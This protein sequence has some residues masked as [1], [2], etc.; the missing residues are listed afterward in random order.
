MTS[1]HK[2]LFYNIIEPMINKTVTGELIH[3]KR[4]FAFIRDLQ[5]YTTYIVRI[6]MITEHG[7]TLPSDPMIETTD[8]A[9]GLY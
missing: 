5:P 2:Y 8:E 4:T 1:K 3:R 7:E 9:G 6:T